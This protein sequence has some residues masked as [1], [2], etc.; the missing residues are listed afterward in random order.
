M[1]T[2]TT[3]MYAT[4]DFIELLSTN[5]IGHLDIEKSINYKHEIQIT[6]PVPDRV[7]TISESLLYEILKNYTTLSRDEI[8][9]E[10]SLK[11]GK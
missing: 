11:D 4:D 2:K 1:K 6:I 3:T 9:K 5:D 10:V 8:M 7:V